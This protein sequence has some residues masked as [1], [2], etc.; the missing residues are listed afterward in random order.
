MLKLWKSI[1]F[2]VVE[3]SDDAKYGNGA[4]DSLVV[5]PASPAP[6][7]MLNEAASKLWRKGV[8][9]PVFEEDLNA[10][11]SQM[12]SEFVDMGIASAGQTETA[13]RISKPV[14]TSI[15]HELVY[16]LIAK[17]CVQNSIEY[18]FVKGP[19]QYDYGLRDRKHSADVDVWIDPNRIQEFLT[20]MEPWGWC[21]DS[22]RWLHSKF[23]HSVTLNASTWGCQIDVHRYFPGSTKSPSDAFDAV[24]GWRDAVHY[25]GAEALVLSKPAAA[26]LYA[27]HGLRPESRHK[28]KT[29][30]YSDAAVALGIGGSETV[31]FSMEFACTDVLFDALTDAFPDEPV[32]RTNRLP[33]DWKWRSES[34]WVRAYFMILKSLKPREW[35]GFLKD[36]VRAPA[37]VGSSGANGVS[38]FKRII[39]RVSP[40]WTKAKIALS[41]CLNRRR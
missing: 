13:L 2:G 23:N 26:V 22:E 41:R 11:E 25:A 17:L 7:L 6:P 14:M 12:I 20:V 8:D 5:L 3:T 32:D 40:Q 37:P 30:D 38:G 15:E 18:V 34:S 24:I 1:G 36:V 16:A 28:K 33:E 21:A 39:Y 31:R 27:L 19:I 9:S 29:M 4:Q 10:D 35:F